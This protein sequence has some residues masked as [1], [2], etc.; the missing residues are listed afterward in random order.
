MVLG[1]LA[2]LSVLELTCLKPLGFAVAVQEYGDDE[3]K[4]RRHGADDDAN[5]DGGQR[6]VGAGNGFVGA[7][8]TVV[9]GH[10]E[11]LRWEPDLFARD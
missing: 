6:M 3:G 5:L 10:F 4:E 11:R 9:E 2:Q 8:V 7:G 1:E